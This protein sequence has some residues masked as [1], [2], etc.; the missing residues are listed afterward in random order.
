MW[1]IFFI[2]DL[3]KRNKILRNAFSL[4][5]LT[6][7]IG[8]IY[9]QKYYTN[10]KKIDSII[11]EQIIE[12]NYKN[13]Q[14]NIYDFRNNYEY[15]TIS[16]RNSKNI[17]IKNFYQDVK[18]LIKQSKQE[19]KPLKP[20]LLFNNRYKEIAIAITTLKELNVKCP[21]KY[22]YKGFSELNLK[23]KK[24]KILINN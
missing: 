8:I 22:Y 1:S 7:F 6:V 19:Q 15:E 13:K 24:M 2:K 17:N 12:K 10:I 14:L 3:E 21:I 18:S 20:I 11:L 9:Y 23:S 5:I 16:L 4:L